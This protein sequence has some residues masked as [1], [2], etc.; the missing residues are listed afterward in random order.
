MK[1][2]EQYC[3]IIFWSSFLV[4]VLKYDQPCLTLCSILCLL[5]YH[6]QLKR[7]SEYMEFFLEHQLL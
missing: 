3:L 7:Q 5:C 4:M 2:Y 1:Y 6:W